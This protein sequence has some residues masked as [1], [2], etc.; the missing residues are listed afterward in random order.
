MS[1]FTPPLVYDRPTFL[2][3][4]TDDQ[5]DLWRHFANRA[6]G[7]NVWILSDGTVV[8]DT[9]TAENSNTDMSNV[10]PWDV[11]DPSAP[12]V[13]SVFIDSGADPQIPSAHTVSHD[14]YPVAFFYGGASHTV[15]SAQAAILTAA[16][17][18]D[19]LT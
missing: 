7:V 18:S 9:A 4:S 15:T 13:T 6:R 19:C 5:K 2:P 14:P 17:Y 8:Q 16:G 1:T 12:Y 11:N 10:Y 3:D